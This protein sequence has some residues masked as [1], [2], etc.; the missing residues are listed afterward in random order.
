MSDFGTY[1]EISKKEEKPIL[2]NE[3]EVIILAIKKIAENEEF[4]D[5]LGEAFLFQ[6][7][8]V[9]NAPSK[10]LLNLSEY[11]YGEG[12]DEENFEFA[13][14]NDLQYAQEI[15]KILEQESGNIFSFEAKFENW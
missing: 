6:L 10:L 2:P 14:D 13:K 3:K 7:N 15:A 4:T 12:E 8:E 11:W 5:S 9:E 1:I